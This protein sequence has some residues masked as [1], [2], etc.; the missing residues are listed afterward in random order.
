MSFLT[1]IRLTPNRNDTG[2]V[3]YI[4]VKTMPLNYSLYYLFKL[5]FIIGYIAIF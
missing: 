4:V 5:Y 2:V 1:D 3:P